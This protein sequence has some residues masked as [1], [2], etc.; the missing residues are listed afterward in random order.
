MNDQAQR[1]QALDITQSYIVQ[2]P[3]GSG[4]TELLTQRY[5]SLLSSCHHPENILA[6]TFTNKAVDEMFERVFL[7]LKSTT[8][9]KPTQAHKQRTY[10][11]ASAVMQRSN[12]LGW[13]L[14]KNPKRLKIITID[15]LASLVNARYPLESQFVPRNI[16]SEQ[17]Q[18]DR[19]YRHAARQVLE[20]IDDSNYT[21]PISALL[22]YLDNH[23]ERF[24]RLITQMLGKRD[25][26]LTRL[27]RDNVLDLSVLSDSMQRII[28]Q[29]L[30]HLEA[31]AKPY[32]D[33]NFFK[34]MSVA[35]RQDFA[36]VKGLPGHTLNDFDKW[37]S[38]QSLCLNQ[39]GN[40]RKRLD[41]NTG[42]PSELKA[43]KQAMQA[44][45][46]QLSE[47]PLLTQALQQVSIL[48]DAV[49]P[50]A[51][52]DALDAIAQV[53]KLCVAQLNLYFEQ[54]QAHD[55]I[56]VALQADKVLDSRLGVSETA[57]FLD[58]KIQH[59]LIDEF[60]DTSVSQ[61]N[62]IEK[63][64][65]TWQLGD[66]KTLFLV[67]DP[68]Q[69][70]YRFRESQVGL[71]LQ[72]KEV[73]IANLKP[74]SL[75][76]NANFR[77]SQS[78]VEGNNTFF[79]SIFPEDDDT[80]QGA[81]SYS[82]SIAASNAI[83]EDA[84]VFH[85]FAHDQSYQEAQRVT[86]L[87]QMAQQQNPDEEV[88]ILVRSRTH[89]AF[90]AQQL[91][92]NQIAFESLKITKL[93]DHLLTRDLL[94]LTKALLHLGDKLAWLSVLRSPWCGLVLD[95]LLTLSEQDDQVIYYQLIDE[96]IQEK[97]THDGQKRAAHL[98]SCLHDSIE[99]QGRFS[100]V[101]LLTHAI[102]Q[103]GITKSL[104]KTDAIIKQ[105]FLQIIANC[106]QQQ[107][108]NGETIL[109]ALEDL[110]A[111]S[112]SSNIKL[113]TIHQSKG[114]EF[115]TVILPGLGRGTKSDDSPMI[116]IKE[117][118]NNLLLLAPIKSSMD[119]TESSTYAYLKYIDAQQSKFETMRL[120]YVAMTRAK[121]KLHLMGAVN[122]NN[123]V[124][125]SSLLAL[126]MRFYRH[127]FEKI[128]RSEDATHHIDEPDL[129]RIS[130]LKTPHLKDQSATEM[131]DYQ[132][133]FD[134]LFKSLIGTLV[135]QY[136]EHENFSPR[137]S[138]VNNRL[139]ELGVSP[140]S[141]NKWCD[142]VIRL[143]HNANTDSNFDW[144]FKPRASTQVEAEFM[145]DEKLIIIDRLFIEDDILWVIDFKT[146]Q[147]KTQETI[148]QF[149]QRQL[150]KYSHQLQLYQQCLS[151]IYTHK[152]QC[153]LY[154][155][156]EKLLIPFE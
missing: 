18:R 107:A 37:Q 105:Q 62:I 86:E 67:G 82:P 118:S 155:P 42:Y 33:D 2:A 156:A 36:M 63:L 44:V 57:L 4:K 134:Q 19:A 10:E 46:T 90:I 85:P 95:D 153:A 106:E 88:A 103:L 149:S 83:D 124:I 144:L 131:I 81:I 47:Q 71:F 129:M 45:L 115:D 150:T 28:T 50:Q 139:I 108:L 91:Q 55:F 41:K 123:E 72:V 27:Y 48:P 113:M 79:Q 31:I 132:H 59:L 39:S 20:M 78:I 146:A 49:L 43:Q 147:R 23:V 34:L 73:G 5:L 22:L 152:I 70:I 29:H 143:L 14:L 9:P 1:D 40:W 7:A 80:H 142:F 68:M 25:Q 38:I 54:V 11:L 135:H 24:Y 133:N 16:M 104:S 3:A 117:F 84:I 93:K 145:V 32:L 130:E 30:E 13:E 6:M 56:E 125:S 109:S 154:C 112:E 120:L 111:P 114:L 61:F 15:G 35:T 140:Q 100:F 77:S 98:Y 116:R 128:D 101:E 51:Q 64:L 138:E 136:L 12:E 137:R 94:S 66:G 127:E 141:I 69:S 60:Q 122:Q 74:T 119:Q 148:E 76:L 58:Y 87:V 102:D 8:E 110:Y 121:R 65:D 75:V 53:L 17:W 89:L 99:N 52:F 92:Q 21:K 151:A 97:L 126:L 96:T 26:W